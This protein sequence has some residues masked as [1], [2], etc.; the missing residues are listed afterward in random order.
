MASVVQ[1]AINKQIEQVQA[2]STVTTCVQ[3]IKTFSQAQLPAVMMQT[4]NSSVLRINNGEYHLVFDQEWA[5]Q[6]TTPD[7]AQEIAEQIMW[8]WL[9]SPYREELTALR[10]VSVILE[11]SDTPIVTPTSNGL[12]EAYLKF[13]FRIGVENPF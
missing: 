13:K 8:I 1:T 12:Y 3:G 11:T 10:V 2:L 4:T 9:V 6:A 5:I 7:I